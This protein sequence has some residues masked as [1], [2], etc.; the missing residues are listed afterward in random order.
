[1]VERIGGELRRMM[2]FMAELSDEIAFISA[3]E[4]SLVDV[5]R[6]ISRSKAYW[7]WPEE[8]LSHAIPLHQITPGYLTSSHCFEVVAPRGEL[9]AFLSVSEGD[10]KVVID[11]LWVAP[12]YIGRGIGK[13]AIRFV[14]KL[15]RESGWTN[16]WVLPDPPAEGFYKAL[17]F[18]D[19]GE[20]VAS[21]VTGGPVF[22]V[23]CISVSEI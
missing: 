20:R 8:Y 23:Y 22:S 21:R 9:V 6:L 19:T 13:A 5:N 15:A 3:R 11:N 17:G 7:D 18:S 4:A 14:F 1:M 10:D 2:R 12:E 16:V